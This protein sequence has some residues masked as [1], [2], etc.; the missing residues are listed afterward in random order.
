MKKVI[1]LAFTMA[2]VSAET[3]KDCSSDATVCAKDTEC[4]G[5]AD[6]KTAG[7]GTK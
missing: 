4:C 2:L 3:G 5:V 6:P 1:L 7:S